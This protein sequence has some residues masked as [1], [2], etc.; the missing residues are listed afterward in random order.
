MSWAATFTWS[1][2]GRSSRCCQ[3]GSLSSTRRRVAYFVLAELARHLSAYVFTPPPSPRVA[4]AIAMEVAAGDGACWS[5]HTGLIY[6]SAWCMLLVLT[7]VGVEK[8]LSFR[9]SGDAVRGLL[10]LFQLGENRITAVGLRVEQ[11]ESVLRVSRT[12]RCSAL[13]A[14][15]PTRRFARALQSAAHLLRRLLLLHVGPERRLYWLDTANAV[16][17]SRER[18]P[19]P[20]SP[21]SVQSSLVLLGWRLYRLATRREKRLAAYVPYAPIAL[22]SSAF[23]MGGNFA[24]RYTGDLW[25]F[26]VLAVVDYRAHVAG[27]GDP[28]AKGGAHGEGDVFLRARPLPLR[29]L[30]PWEW[31]WHVEALPASHAAA[32]WDD[33]LIA[34]ALAPHRRSCTPANCPCEPRPTPTP[35]NQ[36]MGWREG[37]AIGTFT[38]VYLGVAPK[39]DD[40]Y[41]LLIE[42]DGLTPEN[43]PLESTIQRAAVLYTAVARTVRRIAST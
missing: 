17:A 28:A 23:A 42:T 8:R 37:C 7:R 6:L 27:G 24:W 22:L 38:N 32:M 30:V 25:P 15:A 10:A 33:F 11:L 5:D 34:L 1:S 16:S 26:I 4:P 35:Y 41:Q 40:H 31:G 3:G 39:T 12:R 2:A 36:G 29:F 21:S 13:G 9:G 19:K 20:T 43:S 14:R 18:D